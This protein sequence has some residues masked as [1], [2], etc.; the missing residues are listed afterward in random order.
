M[1]VMKELQAALDPEEEKE[2]RSVHDV[3]ESDEGRLE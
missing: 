2:V 3:F 1:R